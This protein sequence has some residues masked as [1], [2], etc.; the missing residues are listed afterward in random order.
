MG[1]AEKT[2]T[3]VMIDA[4][5]LMGQFLKATP[6]NKG[7]AGQGRPKKGALRNGAPKSNPPTRRQIGCPDHSVNADATILGR[8]ACQSAALAVPKRNHESTPRRGR[9]IR[10]AVNQA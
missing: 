9:K 10:E 3:A 5:A 7:T 2:A 4:M 1:S 8:R 6:K